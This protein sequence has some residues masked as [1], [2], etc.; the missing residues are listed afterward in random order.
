[1]QIFKGIHVHT[2]NGSLMGL[3]P[4]IRNVENGDIN[5]TV[6][7][8]DNDSL[9]DAIIEAIRTKYPNCQFYHSAE[10]TD[11]QIQGNLNAYGECSKETIRL[12]IS[13]GEVFKII[14]AF[15]LSVKMHPQER[16]K[17]KSQDISH[18]TDRQITGKQVNSV[19]TI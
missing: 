6:Q 1:M 18:K 4:Y 3:I 12:F 13:S 9:D 5:I 2:D 11:E 17:I 7:G 16:E 19:K 10:M 8:A 15:W 14:L